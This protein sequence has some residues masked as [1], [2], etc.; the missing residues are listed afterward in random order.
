MDQVKVG[1]YIKRKRV[2]RGMTQQVL[3][4]ILNTSVKSVSRWENGSNMPDVSMILPLADAIGVSASELLEGQDQA[5]LAEAAYDLAGADPARGADDRKKKH[6]KLAAR[7]VL[8]VSFLLFIDAFYGY[9]SVFLKWNVSDGTIVPRGILYTVIY[10]NVPITNTAGTA[11]SE[12]FK[13]FLLVSGVFLLA[14]SINCLLYYIDKRNKR[15]PETLL[16]DA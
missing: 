7:V 13:L 3:A 9:F 14:V 16:S 11:V 2:E 8:L 12:M 10:G 5:V 15:T 1:K 6:I 4:D